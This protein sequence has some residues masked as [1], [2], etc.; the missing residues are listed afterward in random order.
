[1]VLQKE[2]R[3]EKKTNGRMYVCGCGVCVWVCVLCVCVCVCVIYTQI[4]IGHRSRINDTTFTTACTCS[5]LSRLHAHIYSFRSIECVCEVS[6]AKYSQN[7][8][9][10][11]IH[12]HNLTKYLCVINGYARQPFVWWF[13][14]SMNTSRLR[15]A[16]VPSNAASISREKS[17][18]WR[19]KLATLSSER[20]EVPTVSTVVGGAIEA[21][22]R[23]SGC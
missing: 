21:S 4:E 23:T 1:M 6:L 15:E 14:T 20:G 13:D 2:A 19:K 16:F 9:K 11:S 12:I 17:E 7:W 18:I 8:L 5:R 3:D 22:W 10:N